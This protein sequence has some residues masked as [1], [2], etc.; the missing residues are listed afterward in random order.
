MTVTF[1]GKFN[2][3]QTIKEDLR[4]GS[5]FKL[6]RK[7]SEKGYKQKLTHFKR[8]LPGKMME[9]DIADDNNY[10]FR[11]RSEEKSG[12]FLRGM[13]G[14]IQGDIEFYPK[15][16]NSAVLVFKYFLNPDY[17]T[18]LEFDSKRNLF[19]NLDVTERVGLE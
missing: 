7:A 6:I 17:T 13:Y 12:K 18:N 10:I 8:W 3:I 4:F 11:T 1:K 5:K 9:S 15:S 14:K 2:G 19:L 16:P